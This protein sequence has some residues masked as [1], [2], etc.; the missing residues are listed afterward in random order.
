MD[1]SIGHYGEKDGAFRILNAHL[2]SLFDISRY[3]DAS[4]GSRY[5]AFADL[6]VGLAAAVGGDRANPIGVLALPRRGPVGAPDFQVRRGEEIL[7]YLE[8]K[9]PGAP[10]DRIENDE[11]LRRYRE[12]PNLI[13]TDGYDFRLYR[14]GEQEPIKTAWLP[15]PESGHPVYLAT[16][17]K[18]APVAELFQTFFSF[19]APTPKNARALATDLARRTRFVKEIVETLLAESGTV[20]NRAKEEEIKALYDAVQEQLIKSITR[21]EFANLYAQTLTYGLLAA[22]HHCAGRFTRGE[23]FDRI[24][25]NLGLLR[26]LFRSILLDDQ[27]GPLDWILDELVQVLDAA[28]LEG[29]LAPQGSGDPGDSDGLDDDPI[30]HFY[31]TFLAEYDPQERKRRGVYYTRRP[32][33]SYIVRSVHTLLERELG[34]VDGF[35]HPEVTVLDPAAGTLTFPIEIFRV[36][37]ETGRKRSGTP[38]ATLCSQL[39]ENVVAFELMMAPYAI[40]HLKMER[41]LDRLGRPLKANERFRL[42]LADAFQEVPKKQ[43]TLPHLGLHAIARETEA[44]RTIREGRIVRAIVGNPPYAG[45]S[46]NGGAWIRD[47][48]A[49]YA[50]PD[51]SHVPGYNQVDGAPLGEKNAKWLQNDYVKFLRFA[52]WKIDQ[53]GSGVVGF[54]TDHGWLEN[55]TFRGLRQSLRQTFETIYALDLH[56]NPMKRDPQATEI[57]ENVFD[58]RQGVA[59]ALLIKG[60]KGPRGVFRADLRGRRRA[61]ETW[62]QSHDVTDTEWTEVTP[63]GP[64]FH[65]QTGDAALEA[66]FSR[67]WPLPRLFPVHSAGIVTSRDAFVLD[68]DLAK[69][70]QRIAHFR[71]HPLMSQGE[72]ERLGLKETASFE[73]SAAREALLGDPDWRERFEQLLYRP[74]QLRHIYYADAMI[75]R[76]RREVMRHLIP[77]GNL[78]LVVPKQS[79]GDFGALVAEHLVG[80]KA[81]AAFDINSV[82]PLFLYPESEQGNLLGPTP[83]LSNVA[84]DV[85]AALGAAHGAAPHPL[86]LFAFAYAILYAPTYRECY[87]APLAR[88]F[89]CVPLPRDRGTFARF[90][91]LG[92]R[93]I[94]AHLLRS[95]GADSPVRLTGDHPV[96]LGSRKQCR[97]YRPD[98]ARVV[99]N[100]KGEAF[101][102]LV[103]EVWGYRI[104]GYRVLDKW[105]EDRA[106]R[107]LKAAEIREFCQIAGA[108]ETTIEIEARIDATYREAEPSWADDT[109]AP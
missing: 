20:E 105:L 1:N 56:G 60:G 47:L 109:I 90:A 103:P 87:R 4:E 73:C 102:G 83:P 92:S 96:K 94:D 13:L 39:L 69:L 7:G 2:R 81:V 19:A 61:K 88:G 68:L 62:L 99:L 104:G 78:A 8:V 58:I 106:G 53:A 64:F 33:V 36:A 50:R 18:A 57:D 40:G 15:V 91:A 55:P 70:E 6:M 76:P 79:K 75:E 23:A 49:G 98:E 100:A 85:L 14:L 45:H 54:V 51:G 17:A 95:A 34:L 107:G 80:H 11:Q 43:G 52:Q 67:H 101:T 82:F 74:F 22:R 66:R 108:L 32:V 29:I 10:L 37:L 59:I 89:P 86:E 46:A 48:L 41:L 25:R 27:P 24:P 16:A 35:A 28:D 9:L 77:P 31:E 12:L 71:N 30:L 65:F 5:P 26:D 84:P 42:F 72:E 97:D 63:R 93:L 21:H 38:Q 44:A 3:D